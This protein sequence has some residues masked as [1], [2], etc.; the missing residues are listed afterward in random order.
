MDIIVTTPKSE[1]ENARKEA[2]FIKKYKEDKGAFRFRTFRF[3][4][5]VEVGDKIFFVNDGFIKG[6][7]TIFDI[8]VGSEYCEVTDREWGDENSI[9][10]KFKRWTPLKNPIPMKGFQGIRYLDRLPEIKEKI[11]AQIK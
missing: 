3:K 7:L 11:M 5:K 8:D 2:E 10:L 4:P 6:Y 1:I 9:V